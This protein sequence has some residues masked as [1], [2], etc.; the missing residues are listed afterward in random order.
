MSIISKLNESKF[1]YYVAMGIVAYPIRLKS[2]CPDKCVSLWMFA[3]V[4]FINLEATQL[5]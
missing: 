4:T 3:S 1:K 5:V 2:L